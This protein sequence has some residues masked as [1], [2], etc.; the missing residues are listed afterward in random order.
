MRIFLLGG[1]KDSTNIIEFI[2]NNY[3][4][5]ILTTTTTEYGAKLARQGGSDDTIARPLLK[6]EIVK[7]ILEDKFDIL[8]DATHPFAEHIT[9][10]S[11]T[12]AKELK[13]P[14]IRFERPVTNFENIDTSCIHYVNSFTEAGKLI[15]EEFREGN[16]LH[17]AGANTMEDVLKNVSTER[18]Y[19]RILKVESS[20]E[21][22]DALGV[23]ADHI[24]PMKGAATAEENIELIEKYEATVMITKESGEIGGVI[25]KIEAAN[26]KNI[27]VI[28][29]QR[30]QIKEVNKKDIVSNLD[31]LDEKLKTYFKKTD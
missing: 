3:D 29:I 4:A 20:L 22:C 8:I 18:F 25:D 10:T 27:S 24:I 9:Q 11:A 16:V 6:D 26:E 7:I 31:E 21:K 30:P 15:S 12:I 17:F 5:Y 28:M 14:Y 19:P 23:E 2:K 13:L 1:T